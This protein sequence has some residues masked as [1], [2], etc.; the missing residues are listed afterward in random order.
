M[1]FIPGSLDTFIMFFHLRVNT[2][3]KSIMS[4][5]IFLPRYKS[6]TGS[7]IHLRRAVGILAGSVFFSGMESHAASHSPLLRASAATSPSPEHLCRQ[8]YTRHIKH[9]VN[10][11]QKCTDAYQCVQM[12]ID[13]YQCV[14][15]PESFHHLDVAGQTDGHVVDG[16]GDRVD[17]GALAVFCVV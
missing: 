16:L 17:V 3:V 13:V 8:G 2:L 11:V 10:F 14:G 1:T 6:G 12:D 9:Y 4:K 5:R 15:V 7:L